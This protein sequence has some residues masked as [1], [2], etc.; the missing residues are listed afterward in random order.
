VYKKRGDS[1]RASATEEL[2]ANA[3]AG[4]RKQLDL[5]RL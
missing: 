3:W 5:A 4:E 1:R 2:L